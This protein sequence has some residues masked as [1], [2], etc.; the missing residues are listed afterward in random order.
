MIG[1]AIRPEKWRFYHV[2]A[3]QEKPG[4]GCDRGLRG[5]RVIVLEIERGNVKLGFEVDPAVPVHRLEVWERIR[6]NGQSNRSAGGSAAP[7]SG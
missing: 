1:A 3:D 2:G 7:A 5:L 4:S 6:A